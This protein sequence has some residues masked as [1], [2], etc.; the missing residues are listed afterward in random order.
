MKIK[1]KISEQKL[2]SFL[3]MLIPFFIHFA[4]EGTFSI[5]SIIPIIIVLFFVDMMYKKFKVSRN[6]IIVVLLFLI[7]SLM[8]M[9]I[10]LI[11]RNNLITDMT[12]IRIGY[13]AVILYVYFSFTR[14]KYTDKQIKLIMK[15]NIVS[16]IILSLSLI[17][18]N[19]IWYKGI[20]GTTIDKNFSGAILA[21]NAL[22]IILLI[23][24]EKKFYNKIMYIISYIL[25]FIGIFFSA[26]RASILVAIL[27][28]II[29]IFMK[30]RENLKTKKSVA[31]LF[32]IIFILPIVVF[33][34]FISVSDKMGG[35]S[36]TIQWY[37]NRYFVNGFGDD[38]V[39]GRWIWW[40]NALELWTSRPLFGYGIGNI[41]ISGNS[42]AVAHNTYLDFLLDQGICGIIGFIIVLCRT[43]KG[44][45]NNKRYLGLIITLLLNILIF[46]ATK[47]LYL[48]Y[49]LIIIYALN[50]PENIKEDNNEKEYK[51][52]YS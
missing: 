24:D 33:F 11:L 27:G 21:F 1:I 7:S 32:V 51:K 30:A 35:A 14:V 29:V 38:S 9:I 22:F 48:W 46:S 25:I 26:S 31:K 42:S 18:V 20:L 44:V 41:N 17:F 39:S 47:S 5:Q 40:R 49:N 10:N 6:L 37:W 13:Y 50:N 52:N 4:I 34:I 23:Y 2:K 8:A 15:C 45:K 3:L 28:S 43:F 36:D 16:S 12:Y 19:H